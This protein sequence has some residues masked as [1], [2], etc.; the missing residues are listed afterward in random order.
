MKIGPQL[1]GSK[2]IFYSNS[3]S[4][5]QQFEQ[6][7]DDDNSISYVSHQSRGVANHMLKIRKL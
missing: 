2:V 4:K 3:K 5:F 7:G 6:S 1:C